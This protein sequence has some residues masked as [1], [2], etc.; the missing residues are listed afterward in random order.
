MKAIKAKN[1]GMERKVSKELWEKGFRFRKNVKNL[2]GK[3][4]ISIKKYKVVIFL[5]SCF[6]HGCKFHCRYP[7]TNKK[8]WYKKISNNINRDNK[9]TK[10]YK[11][12]GWNILRLWEHDLNN[13]FNY[14]IKLIEDLILNSK[15]KI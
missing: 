13:N 7:K 6:W 14:S 4:D 3:P 8:Y 10:Y 2:K 15:N 9:V 5:D 12:N 1:T 11:E